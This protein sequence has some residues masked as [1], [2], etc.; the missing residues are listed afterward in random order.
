MA[1]TY[2][3]K[4]IDKPLYPDII[5]SRPESKATAGKL[6]II[7]G[8]SHAFSAPGLAYNVS[9]QAGIGVSQVLLPDAIKKIVKGLLPDAEFAPSTPSGSFAKSSLDEILRA[10]NWSD[11]VLVAGDVGRNSETAIVL[12]NFVKKYSGL[13]T[14]TQDAVDYFKETPKQIVDRDKTLIVLSLAQLQKIFISTPT[15]IPITYSMTTQQLV[16]ALHDY[17]QPHQACIVTKHNELIFIAKDGM[18]VT[19]KDDREIWRVETAAKA[20]VFWLQNPEKQ[21]EA[22]ASSLIE[23]KD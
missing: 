14:I 16:D 2:W 22:V 9:Q 3:L 6:A 4:Q 10:S 7:G 15:I 8:N 23:Q 20:S 19:Q 13:L 12:E 17:T 18:V 1:N 21:L 11:G 5:W